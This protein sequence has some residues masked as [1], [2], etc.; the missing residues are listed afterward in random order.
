MEE[1][2][3]LGKIEGSRKRG[4]PNMRWS[5]CI[6]A[7]GMIVQELSRGVEDRILWTSL[8]KLSKFRA[9]SIAHN[10]NQLG[11]GKR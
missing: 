10:N 7:I 6:Q 3:I 1:T 5:S 8:I 9:D 4:R 2:I 11:G